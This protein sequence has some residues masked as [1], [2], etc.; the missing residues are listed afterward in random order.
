MLFLS[1]KRLLP[2]FVILFVCA[3][4]A[5]SAPPTP[6]TTLRA[7][8]ALNNEQASRELPVAFEAT[9]TYF[10]GYDNLLFVQDGDVAIFVLATT[11]AKLV[12]GDRVL[13]KGTTQQS[14]RPIVISKNITVLRHDT[15][16][17]PVPATFDE[18][19]SAERDCKL[20]SV[21]A[22]IRTADLRINSNVRLTYRR[23]IRRQNAGDRGKPSHL[24][25]CGRQDFEAL[26]R[27]PV[28]CRGN[29]YRP[30]SCRLS[31]AGSNTKGPGSWNHHLLPAGVG[32]CAAKRL[33]QPVDFDPNQ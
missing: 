26:Q 10:P 29:A 7:L 3:Q 25:V 9:V 12:P 13:V 28:V 20:V 14:F 32:N 18:L 27:Q 16:P 4:I 24:L 6:L 22:V 11:N 15:V 31:C 30:D 17:K 2:T 33:H 23:K 21:R 1:M 8:H 5:L 19:I